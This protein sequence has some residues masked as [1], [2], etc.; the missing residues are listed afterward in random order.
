VSYNIYPAEHQSRYASL[1]HHGNESS[2]K[3]SEALSSENLRGGTSSAT[4]SSKGCRGRDPKPLTPEIL[5][6]HDRFEPYMGK[7]A[8]LLTEHLTGQR[9]LPCTEQELQTHLERKAEREIKRQHAAA[10]AVD[11]KAAT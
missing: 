8:R 10:E 3:I 11:N 4:L 5:L 2:D 7:Q 6:L 9:T 1:K